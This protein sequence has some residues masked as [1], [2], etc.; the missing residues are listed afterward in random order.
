MFLSFERRPAVPLWIACA[1]GLALS[2][3]GTRHVSRDLSS[4][5]NVGEVV[6]PDPVSY[7]HLDVYKRQAW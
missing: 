3:C 6:F 7:T 1:A 5:G 4:A 2:A